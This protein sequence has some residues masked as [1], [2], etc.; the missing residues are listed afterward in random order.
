MKKS[1]C[2]FL[3]SFLTT[4][5]SPAFSSPEDCL[6]NES[7][8]YALPSL[9]ASVAGF[10]IRLNIPGIGR[11]PTCL[12]FMNFFVFST[13]IVSPITQYAWRFGARFKGKKGLF[14]SVLGNIISMGA[15]FNVTKAIAL[16]YKK[17]ASKYKKINILKSILVYGTGISYVAWK[18][19]NAACYVLNERLKN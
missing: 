10:E 15:L 8:A 3:L 11:Y 16:A 6:F 14:V 18:G 1:S 4:S 9:A 2:V 12:F 5:F 17:H 13:I 7:L 19:Y